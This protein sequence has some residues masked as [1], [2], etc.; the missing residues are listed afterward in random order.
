MDYKGEDICVLYEFR[1]RER[2]R[3]SKCGLSWNPWG[4]MVQVSWV[5]TWLSGSVQVKAMICC[6]WGSRGIE[7]KASLRSR[8]EKCEVF[9]GVVESRI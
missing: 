5:E 2:Q 9:E 7:K 8:T 4:R 6:D 3:V 1:F